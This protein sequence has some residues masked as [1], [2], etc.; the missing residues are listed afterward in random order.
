[1][2]GYRPIAIEKII[3]KLYQS[4]ITIRMQNYVTNLNILSINQYASKKRVGAED[5]LVSSS[6][7]THNQS[8][9]GIL[10]H[11]ATFDSSDAC[12][13]QNELI[14]YDKFRYHAGFDDKGSTMIQS[15]L[16]GRKS[17]SI[18]NGIHSTIINAISGPCQGSPP[19]AILR[20]IEKKSMIKDEKQKVIGKIQPFGFM[21][22]VSIM[23]HFT[24]N[25]PCIN[26]QNVK[27]IVIPNQILQQMV[28]LMQNTINTMPSYLFT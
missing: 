7:I 24:V 10:S 9:R 19:A 17:K 20:C 22:D 2:K 28:Y 3:W 12:D 26:K 15:L 4:I 27:Q 23:T 16:I 11:L 18:V 6:T 5:C 14:I 1:M 21:D 13:S 25:F 8:Q